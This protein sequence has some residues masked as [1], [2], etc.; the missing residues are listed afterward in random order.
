VDAV[1]AFVAQPTCQTCMSGCD[2]FITVYVARSSDLLNV[3]NVYALLL[4]VVSS[5]ASGH[6]RVVCVVFAAPLS[7]WSLRCCSASALVETQ[8]THK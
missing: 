2:I 6:R 7:S 8:L 4:C 5:C 3:W 1:S